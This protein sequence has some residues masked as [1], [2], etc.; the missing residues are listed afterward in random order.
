[1]DPKITEAIHGM[2]ISVNIHITLRQYTDGRDTVQVEG[3][4]I[5]ECLIS[6]TDQYPAMSNVL[7]YQNGELRN[8]F[9]IYLNTESAYP[10]E[11]K[12]AV[13]DGDEIHIT[14]FLAGG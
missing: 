7:F 11:L 8:H 13:S 1:M 12:R 10:D 3:R 14:A 5:G 4:T 9:E 6:L 2:T